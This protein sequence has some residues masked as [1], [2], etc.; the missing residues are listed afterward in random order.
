M[1]NIF[2]LFM[3]AENN[4][5]TCIPKKYPLLTMEMLIPLER[6]VDRMK[7][8]PADLEFIDHY[9][10]SIGYPGHVQKRLREEDVYSFD[11]ITE[12]LIETDEGDK[13]SYE[14][15]LRPS[16]ITGSLLGCIHSLMRRVRD[17]EKI[18]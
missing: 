6:R 18:Y 3:K 14:I 1:I 8:T 13:Y 17:G 9:I 11:E 15:D 4:V 16:C 2:K 10:T 12:A 5:S 7:T